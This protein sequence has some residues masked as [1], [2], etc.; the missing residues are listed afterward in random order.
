MAAAHDQLTSSGYRSDLTAIR[1][2]AVLFVVGFH[3]G[4]PRAANGFIGVDIFFVL[5]GYLITGIL[6]AEIERTGNLDVGRFYARRARRLLPASTVV[7][8][9]T[10]VGAAIWL[11]SDSWSAIGRSGIASSLYVANLFFGVTEGATRAS[12]LDQIPLLHFWSLAVEEQFYLVWPVLIM[13]LARGRNRRLALLSGLG[14]LG[15]LSLLYSIWAVA[16]GS[17]WAYYSTVSRGWEFA[18]GGVLAVLA[19]RGW[20]NGSV[21]ARQA[22]AVFGTMF[23]VLA[24]VTV[25]P[26]QFPGL[27]A[28]PVVVGTL[29]LLHAAIDRQG[30]VGQI[31]NLR[32]V[33]FVGELSYSLYLWHWPVLVIG[34]QALGRETL[35]VRGG[36]V[37]LSFGLAWATHRF[38]ENPIRF[39]PSLVAVHYRNA[40][41][42]AALLAVGVAVSAILVVAS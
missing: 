42:A 3:M 11:S 37:L 41:L 14:S 38:I 19:P 13:V 7:I 33:Q 36:L 4:L 24:L 40:Q 16:E 25:D 12:D 39:A 30:V 26:S 34:Q 32:P 29:A 35:A 28:I 20:A 17:P 22:L 21:T 27:G 9:A 31:V 2:L 18:A 6:I 8:V 10:M 1:A 23:L 15:A 5:S